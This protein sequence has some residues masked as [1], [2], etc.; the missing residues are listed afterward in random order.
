MRYGLA[1]PQVGSLAD[2][3]IILAGAL[4]EHELAVVA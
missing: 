2:P 3:S 4:V 1:I